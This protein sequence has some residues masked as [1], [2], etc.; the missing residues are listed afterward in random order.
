MIADGKK[1]IEQL[2]LSDDRAVAVADHYLKRYAG[3]LDEVPRQGAELQLVEL[4]THCRGAIFLDG[5]PHRTAE[6][7][8]TIDRISRRFKGF[9]FG[10]YDLRTPSIDHFRQGHDFKIVELNGVTSEATHIYDP[11]ASL[12]DGWRTLFRQWRTAF[13]IGSQNRRAGQPAVGFGQLLRLLAEYRASSR[14]HPG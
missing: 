6:L 7:E 9:Y 8:A 4:G 1:T 13:E 2:V 5:W 12:I 3:R 14:H 10:R 11:S